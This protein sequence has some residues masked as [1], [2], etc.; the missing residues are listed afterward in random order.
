[1]KTFLR[2]LAVACICLLSWQQAALHRD[3]EPVSAAL[4][5][6]G[7]LSA[8]LTV[9]SKR[10]GYWFGQVLG[11]FYTAEF[12]IR[13]GDWKAGAPLIAW[14]VSLAVSSSILLWLTK[15]PRPAESNYERHASY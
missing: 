12:L 14:A 7:I 4:V 8:Y 1:V 5:F 6:A 2:F 3:W 9:S 11:L 10:R 13:I 15:A